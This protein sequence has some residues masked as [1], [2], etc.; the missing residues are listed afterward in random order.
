M[1]HSIRSVQVYV[2]DGSKRNILKLIRFSKTGDIDSHDQAS[3]RNVSILHVHGKSM[4][5]G[6]VLP[7]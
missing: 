5:L 3:H 2:I 1:M 6:F 4:T 7:A